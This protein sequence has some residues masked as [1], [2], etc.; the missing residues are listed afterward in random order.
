MRV[1]A[2]RLRPATGAG[3]AAGSTDGTVATVAVGVFEMRMRVPARL[4]SSVSMPL[5]STAAI[6]PLRKSRSIISWT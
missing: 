3:D 1:P 4:I 2:A 6:S 5:S